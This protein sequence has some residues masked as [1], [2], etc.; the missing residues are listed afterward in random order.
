MAERLAAGNA[1]VAL[2]ANS[3]ATGAILIALI[4]TFGP[5]SGA[6]FNPAVTLAMCIER[7]VRWRDLLPYA[8]S[9]SAGG[10]LG[11]IAAHAMFALPLLQLSTR[12]RH[13]GGQLISEFIATFGLIL[14]IHATGKRPAV[15]PLTV[16]A[17]ISAAYWFTASTS[18]ANPA[19]T[20]ARG[21]TTTF[22]GIRMADVP[23]FVAMQLLAA[24]V[25]T[26]VFRSMRGA[27]PR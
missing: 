12:E 2:L 6:H 27:R 18:F 16:A 26:F 1:A 17:Y 3:F 13:G 4:A 24:G 15:V 25:A 5:I 23:A 20:L 14:V 7:S 10:L 8:L 21:L 22:A 9:Q 19:V 11:V